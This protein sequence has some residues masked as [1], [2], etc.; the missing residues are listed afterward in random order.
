VL[1]AAHLML[2]SATDRLYQ[3]KSFPSDVDRVAPLK[4]E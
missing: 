3:R 4:L 1:A 2:D